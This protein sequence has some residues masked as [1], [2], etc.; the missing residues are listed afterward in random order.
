MK[1]NVAGETGIGM[2]KKIWA[3]SFSEAEHPWERMVG[4]RLLK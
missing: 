1:R 2:P 3:A 4:Q